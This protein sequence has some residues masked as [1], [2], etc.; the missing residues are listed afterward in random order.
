MIL[1]PASVAQ[2]TAQL[3]A[4]FFCMLGCP[5]SWHKFQISSRSRYLGFDVNAAE[6]ELGVAR[7]K[8]DRIFA[9]L[10]K[11]EVGQKIHRKEVER[12]L[13]LLQWTTWV[14]PTLR[15]WLSTFYWQKAP[16]K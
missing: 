11:L 15:P 8:V 4:A 3:V 14:A 5:I 13:G 6:G 16:W 7:E 2:E 9:F 12:G 1:V 10:D